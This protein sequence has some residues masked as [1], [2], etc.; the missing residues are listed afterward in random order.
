M[1]GSL[2]LLVM[3]AFTYFL[4]TKHNPNRHARRITTCARIGPLYSAYN[5]WILR[6]PDYHKIVP[7]E[8]ISAEKLSVKK[9]AMPI[10]NAFN[11]KH[12]PIWSHS[13]S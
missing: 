8:G 5:S 7:G 13:A 1:S 3:G 10:P 9:L 2:F 12:F 4:F 11:S 6:S